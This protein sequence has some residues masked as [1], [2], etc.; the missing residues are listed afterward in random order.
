MSVNSLITWGGSWEF[1]QKVAV[2]GCE[3]A[4][5][6]GVT[7]ILFESHIPSTAQ[8]RPEIMV[9]VCSAHVDFLCPRILRGCGRY[10]RVFANGCVFAD[11]KM[12]KKAPITSNG[13]FRTATSFAVFLFNFFSYSVIIKL[14]VRGKGNENSFRFVV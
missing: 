13:L 11:A 7:G 12:L 2:L 8:P 3:K 9:D 1:R 4:E 10:F 6:F 5:K 14:I